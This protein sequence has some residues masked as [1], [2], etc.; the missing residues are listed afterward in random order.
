MISTEFTDWVDNLIHLPQGHTVH[1][2]IK[3]IEVRFNL[4]VVIGIVLVV[5]F[6]EHGECRLT[7][8]IVG[9]MLL[10]MG[11]QY[12]EECVHNITVLSRFG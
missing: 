3:F 6:I 9:W 2:L 11:F 1:L 7:V 4:L 10:D 12:F 8:A 5:A